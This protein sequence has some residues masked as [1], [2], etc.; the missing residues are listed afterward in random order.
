MPPLPM[1]R[2]FDRLRRAPMPFFAKP[3]ARG[4]ADHVTSTF[5]AP[6]LKS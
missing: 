1:K 5:I 4:I 3:I 6:N 2:V